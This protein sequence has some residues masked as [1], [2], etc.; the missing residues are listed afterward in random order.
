MPGT[1]Q[2]LTGF[3]A[4]QTQNKNCR[5]DRRSGR[6]RK[7][8]HGQYLVSAFLWLRLDCCSFL[9]QGACEGLQMLPGSSFQMWLTTLG[10]CTK[11]VNVFS[12]GWQTTPTPPRDA[13]W[14]LRVSK[15][16]TM[17]QTRSGGVWRASRITS[18]GWTNGGLQRC[19]P[20]RRQE[21]WVLCREEGWSCVS[22]LCC[23]IKTTGGE[24]KKLQRW[25]KHTS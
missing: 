6:R 13:N 17:W 7:D 24:H 18:G 9:K 15:R 4:V 25:I 11:P 1:L 20:P 5:T 8:E 3:G 14:H 10:E 21:K 12:R 22:L 2:T 23:R 16:E 19:N